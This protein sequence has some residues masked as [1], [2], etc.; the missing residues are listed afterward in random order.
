MLRLKQEYCVG[1]YLQGKLF[2]INFSEMG[3]RMFVEYIRGYL[4]S[5]DRNHIKLTRV[6]VEVECLR[7]MT[8]QKSLPI[9]AAVYIEDRKSV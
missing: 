3:Q 5:R 4:S 7:D 9:H 6:L 1:C 8:K 2:F